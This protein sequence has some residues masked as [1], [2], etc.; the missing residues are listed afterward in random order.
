MRHIV[1]VF[2]A[3]VIFAG[4]VSQQHPAEIIYPSG[5][6][7]VRPSIWTPDQSIAVLMD[8]VFLERYRRTYEARQLVSVERCNNI[9]AKAT[10]F[11]NTH[12]AH[13]IRITCMTWR[14]FKNA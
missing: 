7:Q 13:K 11:N 5:Y 4:Y 9:K 1:A 6:N 14:G 10:E 8:I 12:A 2:F 3:V